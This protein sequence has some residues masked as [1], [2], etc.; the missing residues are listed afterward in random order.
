MKIV[1]V[2]TRG[3]PD[4]QGGVERHC[5]ELYTRLAALGC[6]ITVISRSP[7]TGG[8]PYVY[9]GVQVLPVD[10][11]K[12]KFMEAPI[13]TLLGVLKAKQLKA[14]ILHVHAIGP[15]LFVPLARLL[16]MKV[17]MTHH[18]PDYE[19]KKWNWFAKT[20]LRLGERLGVTC[21]NQVI[22][23]SQAIGCSVR[24][25]F[26]RDLAVIPNGVVVS[27]PA[28]EEEVLKKYDL[29]RGEYI[30]A[31]GRLVPEKGFDELIESFERFATAG[32]SRVLRK[33]LVIVGDADHEDEYSRQLKKKSSR[34]SGVVM[35]GFQTGKPLQELYSHAGLFVLPSYHEGLPITLLEALSYGSSCLVSDIPAN[36]EVGLENDRYFRPGDIGVMTR[37]LEQFVNEAPAGDGPRAKRIQQVV[38]DYDWGQIAARTLELYEGMLGSNNHWPMIEMKEKALAFA[39]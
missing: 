26:G 37:K 11:P 8:T 30:L 28:H 38:R 21:S 9:R 16:G 32:Q 13:H 27:E 5:E 29:E 3:F 4:V 1:V 39:G 36:R 18:G 19:R 10:C 23:V 25:R 14:K 2:G 31:V 17:V 35:T 20:I 33:K 12:H 24:A 34:I 7:Y 22:A 6:D 15:S